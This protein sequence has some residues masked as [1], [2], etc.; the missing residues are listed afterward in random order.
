M[1]KLKRINTIGGMRAFAKYFIAPLFIVFQ[2]T[3]EISFAAPVDV[4]T[5]LD[6]GFFVA[7]KLG[8]EK[9]NSVFVVNTNA[10]SAVEVRPEI[11]GVDAES[12]MTLNLKS[13]KDS[14]EN[15]NQIDSP[16]LDDYLQ[17]IFIGLLGLIPMIVAF[18]GPNPNVKWTP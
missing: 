13:A 16:S 17:A 14:N 9:T 1:C 3:V 5:K 15:N 10:V 6:S 12:K 8:L 18:I 2:C 11:I 7:D 4:V